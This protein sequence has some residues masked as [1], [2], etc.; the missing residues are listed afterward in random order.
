MSPAARDS[1]RTH[2]RTEAFKGIHSAIVRLKNQIGQNQTGKIEMLKETPAFCPVCQ[3]QVLARRNQ[4][5]N[6]LHLVLTCVT[7]GLWLIPWLF[8]ATSARTQ[9]YFCPNCGT[10]LIGALSNRRTS[11]A[12]LRS[13]RSVVIGDLA[14]PVTCS[15]CG[16]RTKPGRR[17]TSCAAA[18]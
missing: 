15:A 17:C 12:S 13:D 2:I 3:H 7:A 5:S 4:A 6:L 16:A 14:D 18:L 11:S 1:R 10:P 8:I 9:T